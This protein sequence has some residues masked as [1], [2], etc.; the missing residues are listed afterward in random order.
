[1]KVLV[2]IAEPSAPTETTNTPVN[3][4]QMAENI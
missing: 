4:G 2:W 1:M 3:S